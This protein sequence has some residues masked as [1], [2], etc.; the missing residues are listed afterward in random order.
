MKIL[1]VMTHPGYARNFEW[2][3]RGLAERGHTVHVAVEKRAKDPGVDGLLESLAEEDR[4][5]TTGLAPAIGRRGGARLAQ[6]IRLWL[7]YL[8]YLEPEFAEATKLRD[9]GGQAPSGPGPV[10]QLASGH[11]GVDQKSRSCGP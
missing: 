4:C 7:D 8:R 2:V 10:D 3:V 9:S 1:L 11:P 5:I 6:A